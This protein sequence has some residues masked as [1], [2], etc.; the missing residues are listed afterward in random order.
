M[1]RCSLG[2][3]EGS[4]LPLKLNT[5]EIIM[6]PTCYDHILTYYERTNPE[7]YRLLYDPEEDLQ[8]DEDWVAEQTKLL[9]LPIVNR[10]GIRAYP[11]AL[12]TKRLG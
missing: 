5:G 9:G 11:T 1:V 4:V 7:A 6:V 10:G 8:E 12:I 2:A 3:K